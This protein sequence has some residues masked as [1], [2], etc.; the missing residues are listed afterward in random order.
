MSISDGFTKGVSRQREPDFGVCA[1][2]SL[3]CL[4]QA[5][6]TGGNVDSVWSAQ[7]TGAFAF[8]SGAAQPRV[9]SGESNL[10]LSDQTHFLET[11]SYNY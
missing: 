2:Q 9:L 5:R 6:V 8:V 3:L 1:F 4:T 10:S 7:N 11:M